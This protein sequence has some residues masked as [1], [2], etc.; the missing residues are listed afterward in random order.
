[1]IKWPWRCLGRVQTHRPSAMRGVTGRSPAPGWK[2][3]LRASLLDYLPVRLPVCLSAWL[4]A[5]LLD[6]LPACLLDYLPAWLPAC[7]PAWLPGLS[8]CLSTWLPASTP[9]CLPVCLITCLPAW[10]PACLITC[11]LEY[12]PACL[13]NY[14]PACLLD[15]LPACLSKLYIFLLII[16]I[17]VI[18]INEKSIILIQFNLAFSSPPYY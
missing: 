2:K 9:A 17:R 15:Y 14:L 6:Y 1:M 13:L 10:L 3:Q 4:P 16:K 7:L 11:L 5:C 12:L 8:A 18:K